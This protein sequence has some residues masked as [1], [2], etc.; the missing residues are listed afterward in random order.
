MVF[1]VAPG[2]PLARHEGPI[3]EAAIEPHRSVV[4]ADS[5]RRL[6]PRSVGTLEGQETLVVPD[7]PA[8]VAAQVAGLGCGWV[9]G[10]LAADHVA[11][12]R[13]VV[14]STEVPRPDA[15]VQL[16]WRDARPGK[17][18]AWWV[19]AVTATDWR[20]LALGAQRDEAATAA[21]QR[22]RGP[23]KQDPGTRRA[24]A[25]QRVPSR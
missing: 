11:A 17:A 3:A 16:V 1:A 14:K 23:G 5:S 7:L 19:D 4:A 8:K 12:G 6:A 25:R 21:S 2:H 18:L 13:L 24:P 10:Y 9:P 22:H 20:F 15:R